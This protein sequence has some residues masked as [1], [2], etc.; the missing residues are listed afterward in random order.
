MIF[1]AILTE[2]ELGID[3]VICKVNNREIAK[4]EAENFIDYNSGHEW[5]MEIQDEHGPDCFGEVN[6]EGE[7]VW[8]VA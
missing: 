4:S 6:K 1:T 2:K 3:F 7:I 8:T 5:S